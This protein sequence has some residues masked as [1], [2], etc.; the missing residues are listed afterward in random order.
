MYN[1]FV[2]W[3]LEPL[4]II[5]HYFVDAHECLRYFVTIV[6]LSHPP[7]SPSC[8]VAVPNVQ[9]THVGTFKYLIVIHVWKP[10]G[11]KLMRLMS[12]E[13]T[14]AP[15]TATRTTTSNKLALSYYR[16]IPRGYQLSLSRVDR[17]PH[18]YPPSIVQWTSSR[19]YAVIA[20]TGHAYARTLALSSFHHTR[21]VAHIK[22]IT[23]HC[24]NMAFYDLPR[25]ST[26]LPFRYVPTQWITCVYTWLYFDINTFAFY[27]YEFETSYGGRQS[28]ILNGITRHRG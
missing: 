20:I 28:F 4:G 6:I 19:S 11:L 23:V 15:F 3:V 25:T 24:A 8:S 17:S 10:I 7:F 2:I 1:T 14:E 27:L 22:H 16:Y 21:F 13:F 18:T 26:C 5:Y 12:S 9:Y